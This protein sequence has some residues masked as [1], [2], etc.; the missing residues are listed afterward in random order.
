MTELASAG[1]DTIESSAT[2]TLSVNVENLILTGSGDITG[3]GNALANVL[4]GNAGS[5]VLAGGLGNDTYIISTGDSIV[6]ALNGGLDLVQ[7][8]IG[9]NLGV[10]SNLENLTLLL[11]S[12]NASTARATNWPTSS[13]VMRATT[14]LTAVWAST[15][16]RVVRATTPIRSTSP[17]P[18]CCKTPSPRTQAKAPTRSFCVAATPFLPR[19]AACFRCLTES[20]F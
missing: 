2:Y 16:S 18:T 5:N 11:G 17:R 19:S 20:W 12:G 3:T 4:S 13:L 8:D 14:L 7:S 6:E 10:G 9:Y 1:T 15:Y